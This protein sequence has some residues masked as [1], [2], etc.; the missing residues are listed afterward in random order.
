[1]R[2]K[3]TED[4]LTAETIQNLER[5]IL[6]LKNSIQYE[7]HSHQISLI[8]NL[9]SM[10][11]GKNKP[12]AK[13]AG[14]IERTLESLKIAVAHTKAMRDDWSVKKAMLIDACMK[15][16][17][18][19]LGNVAED[20]IQHSI[21]TY[22]NAE[23]RIRAAH[24][25]TFFKVALTKKELFSALAVGEENLAKKIVH[26]NPDLLFQKGTCKMPLLNQGET[27]SDESDSTYYD[28]TPLQLMLYTGN[29][30]MLERMFPLIPVDR[31]EE[32]LQEMRKISPVES[33]NQVKINRNQKPTDLSVDELKCFE[34]MREEWEH[35]LSL[36]ILYHQLVVVTY[37]LRREVGDCYHTNPD[38]ENNPQFQE[39]SEKLDQIEHRILLF[40]SPVPPP[41]DGTAKED[42]FYEYLELYNSDLKEL[43][44]EYNNLLKV[45]LP[46]LQKKLDTMKPSSQPS[47]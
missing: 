41:L 46:E 29:W 25:S 17:S 35:K 19:H 24:G 9:Q 30:K 22:L 10:V 31:L 37:D 6:F 36:R 38:I 40:R 12:S 2:K 47:I 15:K 7:P 26:A 28:T 42:C 4:Q 5:I 23:E 14:V 45:E 33:S 1:M 39:V 27:P 21:G 43:Q 32:T 44:E 20:N 8:K 34:K 18:T 11:N 13:G 16:V 3:K